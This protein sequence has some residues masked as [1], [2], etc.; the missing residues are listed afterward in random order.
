MI[1]GWNYMP[2]PTITYYLLSLIGGVAAVIFAIAAFKHRRAFPAAVL[3]ILL[4][5]L[6]QAAGLTLNSILCFTPG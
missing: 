2:S 1:G 3:A 4:L 5:G 6:N